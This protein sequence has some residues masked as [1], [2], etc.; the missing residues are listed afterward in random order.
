MSA[1]SSIIQW[2]RRLETG[3]RHAAGPL[4]DRYFDRLV[5]LARR[6]LQNA[7]RRAA[8]EE[9]V[10]LSVLDSFCRRA[11]DHG[12]EQVQSR[13]GLWQLLEQ[14]TAHKVIDHVRREQARKRGGT[15][16]PLSDA[17]LE[18]VMAADPS[19]DLVVEFAEECRHLLAVLP[20]DELRRI[21][22]L[23]MDGWEVKDIAVEIG[24]SPPT[25]YRK[26]DLIRETW[27]GAHGKVSDS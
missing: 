16:P 27:W 26:I 11:V 4:W 18:E 9:D 5:R 3:D 23:R 12:F 13:A 19:P 15:E 22:R 20:S 10:A 8:D 1:P 14:I 21:A 7:P 24:C 2:L 6:Q 17:H 25:V